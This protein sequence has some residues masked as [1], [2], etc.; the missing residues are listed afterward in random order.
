MLG[1]DRLR[2][3][4]DGPDPFVW[5]GSR[6]GMGCAF[7]AIARTPSQEREKQAPS[8]RAMQLAQQFRE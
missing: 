4:E 3:V 7:R 5:F 1:G 6:L 2:E 8:R